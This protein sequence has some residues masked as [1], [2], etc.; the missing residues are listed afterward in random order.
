M[1]S[2]WILTFMA[3]IAYYYTVIKQVGSE[4]FFPTNQLSQRVFIE[5]LMEASYPFTPLLAIQCLKSISILYR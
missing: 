5:R 2:G 1:L 4:N 3:M